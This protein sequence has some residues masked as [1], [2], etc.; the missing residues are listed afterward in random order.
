MYA[1]I[2][3][4]GKQYRVAAG[5]KNQ[6][7]T[8]CCGCR[9]R[10]VIDQV[11]AVGKRRRHPGWLSPVSGATVTATVLARQ[12]RQGR[13]LQDA[14]SHTTRSARVTASSSQNCNRRDRW[15]NA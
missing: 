5:E 4:G 1:V 2:K 3:T 7:E 10:D 9:P 14:S 6:S 15:L 11:L 12:A 13:H 8:D